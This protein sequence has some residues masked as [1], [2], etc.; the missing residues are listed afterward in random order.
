MFFVW[1]SQQRLGVLTRWR[2]GLDGTAYLDRN[3]LFNRRQKKWPEG[4]SSWAFRRRLKAPEGFVRELPEWLASSSGNIYPEANQR[5][6]SKFYLSFKIYVFYQTQQF[7][8]YF[9]LNN[10]FC[11]YQVGYF[12]KRTRN[13]CFIVL[14]RVDMSW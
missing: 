14:K 11:N 7:F 2:H 12:L 9:V 4:P 6:W 13:V 1:N 5:N 3:Y 10:F 8:F